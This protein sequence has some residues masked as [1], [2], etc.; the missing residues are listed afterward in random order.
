MQFCSFGYKYGIPADAD[1]VFDLRCLPNPYWDLQLRHLT[2]LDE[3]VISFLDAQEPVK[4]MHADI[5]TFLERWIP[6]YINVS[7][8]YLTVAVG[9][10]GGRHRSVAISRSIF[11]HLNKKG[12]NPGLIHRDIDRDLKE[13]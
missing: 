3:K 13:I 6:E 5:L 7:R 9:C 10:T 2:G 11:E 8:G 1:F 4:T 12:L